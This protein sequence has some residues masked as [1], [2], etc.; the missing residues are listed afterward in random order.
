MHSLY[1]TMLPVVFGWIQI[2]SCWTEC[3]A[4]TSV[5]ADCPSNSTDVYVPLT[6]K[7]Q[8]AAFLRDQSGLFSFSHL[9]IILPTCILRCDTD[10]FF[11][12]VEMCW[13]NPAVFLDCHCSWQLNESW[14]FAAVSAPASYFKKISRSTKKAPAGCSAHTLVWLRRCN[15]FSVTE[16]LFVDGWLN[17]EFHLARIRFQNWVPV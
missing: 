16:G 11:K 13:K 15:L 17:V 9:L 1:I 3:T 14:K 7:D 8:A 5:R 2:W 10:F 6:R 4:P 12:F